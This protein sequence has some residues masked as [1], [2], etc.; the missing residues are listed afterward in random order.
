MQYSQ[1]AVQLKKC[2]IFLN[3]HSEL[4]IMRLEAVHQIKNGKQ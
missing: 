1:L 4:T 3:V 2:R